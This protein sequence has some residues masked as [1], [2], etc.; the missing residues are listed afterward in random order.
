ME[1]DGDYDEGASEDPGVAD[2]FDYFTPLGSENG[3]DEEAEGD[4]A[5]PPGPPSNLGSDND[6]DSDPASGEGLDGDSP[7]GSDSEPF[8]QVCPPAEARLPGGRRP[9]PFPARAPNVR[10]HPPEADGKSGPRPHR[11]VDA[12]DRRTSN[13]MTLA[14]TT[15]AIALRAEQLAAYPSPYIDI[16]DLSDPKDIARAELYARRSPLLLHRDVG[17][18]ALGERVT[19]VWQV[20]EMAYP[21]L[22]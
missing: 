20:R 4:E 6:P 15:R 10:A 7:E 17:R 13:R 1:G 2:E 9:A 8:C 3:D 21:V 16:G 22:D 14:E 11:I 19:E 12:E 18:T 5:A